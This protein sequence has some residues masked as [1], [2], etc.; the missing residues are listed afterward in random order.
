MSNYHIRWMIRRD[1]PQVLWLDRANYHPAWGEAEYLD[2]L[3]CRS[4]IGMVAEHGDRLVG[5]MVYR[6]HKRHLELLRCVAHPEYDGVYEAL[7]GKLLSK[8]SSHRRLRLLA[9]VDLGDVPLLTAMRVAGCEVIRFDPRTDE[10]G[11]AGYC[12][13]AAEEEPCNSTS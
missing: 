9:E 11:L 8:L 5:A 6:L 13:A 2:H 4:E 12:H 10:V 1:M 7:V 3:R